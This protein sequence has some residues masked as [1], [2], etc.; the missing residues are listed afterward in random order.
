MKPEH[1]KWIGEK[2]AYLIKNEGYPPKQAAAI[3]Y[4]MYR[5]MHHIALKHSQK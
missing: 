2:I 4:S 3:A 5:Q 1:H